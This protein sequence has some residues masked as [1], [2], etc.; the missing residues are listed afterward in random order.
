MTRKR[1]PPKTSADPAVPG[2]GA[3]A[4]SVEPPRGDADAPDPVAPSAGD[5]VAHSAGT[6]G[7]SPS[8]ADDVARAEGVPSPQDDAPWHTAVEL[9][10]PVTEDA[11]DPP[12]PVVLPEDILSSGEA[13]GER[14][15]L[16]DDDLGPGLEKAPPVVVGAS[17]LKSVVEAL[18]FASDKPVTVGELARAANA[19]APELKPLISDLVEEYRGRGVE[20]VEVSG[21]FQ[22]RTSAVAAPFVRDYVAA[23]PV[24]L[25]RAQVETLS[26]VAYRQPVTRPEIDDIRGVDSGSALK[27]LLDRGLLKIL[28]KKEEAGRPLIY[29]TTAQFLEFFSLASL[30]DL[31]TLREFSEL[32][33]E[34]RALFERRSGEPLGDIGV[35]RE[36]IAGETH[37]VREAADREASDA[38]A[39]VDRDPHGEVVGEGEADDV[40][41]DVDAARGDAPP[42]VGGA[43]GGDEAAADG[44]ITPRD[45]GHEGGEEP[46]AAPDAATDDEDED[47]DEG[48][49]DDE[50]DDDEDEDEDE[51]DE[52]DEDDD[53]A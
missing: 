3:G 17:H 9:Q 6:D 50:D 39:E 42:D 33:D 46:D 12:L 24:R 49:D 22:F 19:R 28:G 52:E 48:D 45:A 4:A 11:S 23:K 40:P 29:G 32:S 41:T 27:V 10:A 8:A 15:P 31:P 7:D 5:E 44:D 47:D 1:Q 25:S 18:I 38:V 30:R 21:G 36:E 20:L 2:D 16:D 13:A 26:I 35:S 43:E 14:L 53:D 37:G 34:S 51:D